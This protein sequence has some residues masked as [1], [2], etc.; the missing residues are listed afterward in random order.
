MYVQKG[1]VRGREGHGQGQGRGEVGQSSK[2]LR[3]RGRGQGGRGNKPDI[4]YYN[5]ESTGIIF[6]IVG[7]RK[8]VEGKANYVEVKKDNNVLLMAQSMSTPQE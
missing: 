1:Q 7:P 2:N 3:G 5:Y 6:E 8:K 4:D